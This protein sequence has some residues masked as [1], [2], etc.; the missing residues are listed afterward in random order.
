M[1]PIVE[2]KRRNLVSIA[3][4]MAGLF[5]VTPEGFNQEAHRWFSTR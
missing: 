4:V 5:E 1:S 3:L 2:L